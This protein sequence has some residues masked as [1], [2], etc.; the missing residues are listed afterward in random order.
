VGACVAGGYAL[1]GAILTPF[2]PEPKA[3]TSSS[4]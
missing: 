3:D 1:L 2:L 4:S